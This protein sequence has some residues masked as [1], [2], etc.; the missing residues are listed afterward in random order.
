MGWRKLL[1]V[2]VILCLPVFGCQKTCKP[3][4]DVE[5]WMEALEDPELVEKAIDNLKEI[6]DKKA[7][8]ALIK[9]FSEFANKPEY[10]ERIAE[11]FR[12]WGTKGAV[13][14]MLAAIDFTV[15]PNKDGRKAKRTNRANQK[16][17]TA[18]GVLGDKSAV[19]SLMRLVKTTREANVRR[20]AIRALGK[21]KATE[22]VD[23]LLG[24][25]EDKN[26]HK[27]IRMNAVYALGEIGDPK[28]VDSLILS[29]Y[30]EKAFFFFQAGLALV[31]IGEP[32]I[33]PLVATM[34]GKNQDAKRITEQNMEVLAGALESNAA[35]VLG[36]IGSVKA[37]EP[38]LEMVEKVGK[39]EEETNRLLVMT[40]LINA[41]SII[42]DERG[43]PI[44]IK[45]LSE[46]LW[47]VRTICATA[48]NNIGK[49]EAIKELIK[50]AST[51]AH[52]KTRAPLIEAIGNLGTDEI[53]PEL[54]KML[55]TQKDITVHKSVEE[56][57]KRIE[58]FKQCKS[59]VGCWIGKLESKEA[60]VREK[61]AF[62]LGRLG[63]EKAVDALIKILND[64]IEN[65]R[66][67]I[68]WALDELRSKKPIAAIEKL[69]KEEKG[70]RRFKIVNYNYQLLAAR[71]SRVGK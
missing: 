27:I 53:L 65:V 22:A 26:T 64:P 4:E 68:I 23:E 50:Y 61:A 33:E 37:V 32:A 70:S 21:L 25:S 45:Y 69:V 24:L 14:P 17:A 63:D 3:G 71:L 7:E 44:A 62:E 54:K 59:D 48:I 35:K 31:K 40:R 11:I 49:R 13:K 2:A 46:E 67:S 52:P 38:L 29:L 51:G 16:I 9:A 28:A 34:N 57:I 36:D 60:A 18:L 10:R 42:G 56:S 6:G 30:R 15:G 5:C 19:Q 8:P 43:L 58:A 47:D 39:W 55:E 41:L 20:A 66:F 12:K 1:V